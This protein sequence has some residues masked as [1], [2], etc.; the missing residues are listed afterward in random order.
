MFF[1]T[2]IQGVMGGHDLGGG[3][4]PHQTLGRF[5]KVLRCVNFAKRKHCIIKYLNDLMQERN[6]EECKDRIQVCPSVELHFHKRRHE[7]N[8]MQCI[9]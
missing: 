2:K 7:G 1:P 3:L 5:S 9:V 8:A 6:A 4:W